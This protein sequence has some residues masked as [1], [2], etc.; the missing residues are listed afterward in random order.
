LL[1]EVLMFGQP[2][3]STSWI[4]SSKSISGMSVYLLRAGASKA[5]AGSIGS[6]GSWWLFS[7]PVGDDQRLFF[8]GG[9]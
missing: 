3:S 4:G 7:V 8:K 1:S 9:G 6:A 2:C 5:A